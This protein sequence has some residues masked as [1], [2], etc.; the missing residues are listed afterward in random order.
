MSFLSPAFLWTLTALLPLAAIYFLKV[1][2]RSRPVS[3]FFLWDQILGQKKAAS[4][5]HRLRDALSLLLLLLAFA[6]VALALAKPKFIDD[7]RKDLLLLI[8]QS[9]SMSAREGGSSRL[10]TAKKAAAGIV[11]AM[12]GNQRA[13]IGAVGHEVRFLS[14]LSLSPRELSGAI[15][16]I[17]ETDF[18]FEMAALRGLEKSQEG[19]DEHRIV[20]LSDGNFEGSESLPEGI[21]LLKI[22]ASL[23]NAGIVRADLQRLPDGSLGFFFQVASSF[24]ETVETDLVVKEQASGD[25]IYKLIPLRIEPGENA[26][27]HFT[28]EDAP[29]GAWT[30]SL[31]IDDALANDNRVFL[32]VPEERPVKVKVA[33][34]DRFFFDVSVLAFEEGGGRLKLVEENPEVEI[35]SGNQAG[36]LTGDAAILFTPGGE[37]PW[38]TAAGEAVDVIAPRALLADHPVIRHLDLASLSFAGARQVTAPA[39]ALV[40]VESERG[41]P[42]LYQMQKEGRRVLVVNLDPLASEFVLSPWF[43]VLIHAAA[44]HL[45]GREDEPAPL[46]RPGDRLPIPGFREGGIAKIRVPGA[47]DS[48][49]VTEA[50]YGPIASLGFYEVESGSASWTFGSSLVTAAES[51]LDSD[52]TLSMDRPLARGYAPSI[53]L[54]VLVIVLLVA[55]SV[56]YH[57]RKVG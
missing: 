34:G 45:T 37:S 49:D 10:E 12:N 50:G 22:G 6:A 9:A 39:G 8:D 1:R 36:A 46:Y 4:L 25:R 55:E 11:A 27:E 32:S 17:S 15:E 14:H 53:W 52:A 24:K 38:W 13:A 41:V 3:A 26:P 40:I 33:S 51:L 56:L 54:L 2:P 19:G 35:S 30:A 21:E 20:L 16:Q 23:G 47:T 18:P 28:L 42:L 48:I 57:R 43:P 44:I 5:L 29:A 31:E 7:D